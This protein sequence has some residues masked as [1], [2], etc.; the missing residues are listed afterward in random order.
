MVWFMETLEA[1]RAF[2]LEQVRVAQ[3]Q[4]EAAMG[5]R[6]DAIQRAAEAG[7]ALREI[8]AATGND[9]SYEVIRR[10]VGDRV[11]VAINWRGELYEISEPQVR[12]LAYKA[13]GYGR[14]AFPGDVALLGAGD[15]WLPASNGLG[16]EIQKRHA[17]ITR[18]PLELDDDLGLALCQIL[19]LTYMTR[20]SRLADLSDA[21]CRDLDVLRPVAGLR[22]RGGPWS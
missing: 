20:P 13:D 8:E 14:N 1:A 4:V 2:A 6:L 15:A 11:R 12:A 21:L 18:D 16:W 10:A 3:E 19:R 9:L 22:K 17:G 5:A 7:C